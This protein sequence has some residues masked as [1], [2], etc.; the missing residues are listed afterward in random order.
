MNRIGRTG[1]IVLFWAAASLI[2]ALEAVSAAALLVGATAPR[3]Y[4]DEKDIPPRQVGMVLGCPEFSGGRPSPVLAGRLQAA[5]ELYHAGKVRTLVVSGASRPEEFY[6]EIHAMT[7]DLIALGVPED[8]I[9]QDG[10]GVRTLD[11]ILRMR[12]VFGYD[13]FIT[14][15]QRD[16]CE[17]ALY[18]ADHHN[19][20]T[21][22]FEAGILPGQYPNEILFSTIREALARVKAVLDIA[23]DRR[24]KYPSER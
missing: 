11:S 12:D 18:L 8:A 1:R 5:A 13:D 6:D 9:I 19:I 23:I 16:H 24:A 3:V 17:R 21:I 2:A 4:S 10:K 15:S 14:I 20:S 22:G 7:R